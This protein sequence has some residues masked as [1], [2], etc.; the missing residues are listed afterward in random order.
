MRRATLLMGLFVVVA[1]ICG[2]A[3][4]GDGIPLTGC[5]N[6]VYPPSLIPMWSILTDNGQGFECFVGVLPVEASTTIVLTPLIPVIVKLHNSDGTFIVSDPTKPLHINP[7]K[8]PSWSAFDVTAASPIFA[9]HDYKLGSTNLGKLQYGEM[10]ERASFWKYPG[11]K[12]D[13]WF[14]ELALWPFS[15]AVTLDIPSGSWGLMAGEAD[16]YAVDATMMGDFLLKQAKKTPEVVPIFLTYNIGTYTGTPPNASCCTLGDHQPYVENGFTSFYI[17]ASYMDPPNSRVDVL[18]LSHEVAEFLH[19]PFLTNFVHQYPLP[20]SFPL[21]WTPSTLS[22]GCGSKLEVGDATE[23][24]PASEFQIPIDTSI[25]TYH[26]QNI[27]TASW[28]MQ[29]SPSFSVDGRYTLRG[30]IDE[31]FEGPAPP[32]NTVQ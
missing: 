18:G 25:M 9:T 28:F 16:A 6:P 1:A 26:V 20:G 14:V 5:L 4:A 23:D 13:K 12:L 21:P 10:T 17:W 11:F 8:H 27:A 7:T 32:C 19:D 3:R 30:A 22:R 24:R 15:P 31:E 2:T 29:A